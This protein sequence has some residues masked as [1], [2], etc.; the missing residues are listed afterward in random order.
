MINHKMNLI[1]A[2]SCALIATIINIIGGLSIIFGLLSL[3]PITFSLVGIYV[4]LHTISESNLKDRTQ[5][6][7]MFSLFVLVLGELSLLAGTPFIFILFG[8]MLGE[9]LALLKL[10]KK[11]VY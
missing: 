10:I 8:V 5:N 11:R 7:L 9:L 4:I 2:W 3:I 1:M 6:I